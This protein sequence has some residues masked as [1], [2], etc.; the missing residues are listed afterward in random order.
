MA[1]CQYSSRHVLVVSLSLSALVVL[2]WWWW[3]LARPYSLP[4]RRLV[5]PASVQGVE[6]RWRAE[7]PDAGR[8]L[9]HRLGH[10]PAM[11]VSTSTGWYVW[12]GRH[13]RA[14]PA[15]DENVQAVPVEFTFPGRPRLAR[16]T[17]EPFAQPVTPQEIPGCNALDMRHVR[18]PTRIQAFHSLDEAVAAAAVTMDEA[19]TATDLIVGGAPAHPMYYVVPV[20]VGPGQ[21]YRTAVT[22]RPDGSP[23]RVWVVVPK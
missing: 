21:S 8:R 3:R 6:R 13:L 19:A 7:T 2:W 10:T 16:L 14:L 4:L 12:S 1:P 9:L 23:Q 11:L 15:T 22:N 5:D 20:D 18:E 17:R